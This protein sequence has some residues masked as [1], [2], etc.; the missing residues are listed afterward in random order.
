MELPVI[1]VWA[2]IIA[3]G[4]TVLGVWEHHERREEAKAA[5]RLRH[6]S[7]HRG[8]AHYWAPCGRVLSAQDPV[9][10]ACDWIDHAAGCPA[11]RDQEPAA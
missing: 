9:R 4:C 1:G 7:M 6:P 8:R 11:E 3:A 5:A 10:L 2:G